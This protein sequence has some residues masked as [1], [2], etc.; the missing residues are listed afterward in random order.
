M[1]RRKWNDQA[2]SSCNVHGTKGQKKL[3][4]ASLAQFVVPFH[5][6]ENKN[7]NK[8]LGAS[9]MLWDVWISSETCSMSD[10]CMFWRQHAHPL[11]HYQLQLCISWSSN[12]APEIEDMRRLQH[13]L[14]GILACFALSYI[15]CLH[16]LTISVGVKY[17]TL[18]RCWPLSEGLAAPPRSIRV[19]GWSRTISLELSRKNCAQLSNSTM[20]QKLFELFLWLFEVVWGWLMLFDCFHFAQGFSSK[21]I[22]VSGFWR[23]S[24]MYLAVWVFTIQCKTPRGQIFSF[25]RCRPSQFI[26]FICKYHFYSRFSRRNLK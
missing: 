13:T 21:V 17:N 18:T 3:H 26:A 8:S 19:L 10:F 25:T 1:Y 2:K 15:N 5:T 16:C 7:K 22:N 6:S 24:L 9:E 12:W 23:C 20:I 4:P 11:Q 14:P